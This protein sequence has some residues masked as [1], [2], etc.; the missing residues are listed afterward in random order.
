MTASPAD[1]AV[2]LAGEGLPLDAISAETGLSYDGVRSALRRHGASAVRKLEVQVRQ[3]AEAMPP[4]E[5]VDYLLGVVEALIEAAP[6]RHHPTDLWAHFPIVERRVVQALYE[7][8][9][10][11]M[12]RDRLMAAVYYD[13]AIDEVPDDKII[14]IWVCKIRKKL[15]DGVAIETVWGR[16]WR[17]V[18]P[19][20]MRGGA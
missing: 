14:D 17:M 10:G 3:R 5:A 6:G 8:R 11:L 18:V 9:G 19:D 20:Q 12:S 2:A 1:M 7:A 13:R 16:G 15:P 4:R